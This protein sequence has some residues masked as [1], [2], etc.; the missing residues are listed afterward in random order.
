MSDFAI[1]LAKAFAIGV[2][3]VQTGKHTTM[4]SLTDSTDPSAVLIGL[5]L[6]AVLCTV[7]F[8]QSPSSE[9]AR[10]WK[11]LYIRGKAMGLPMTLISASLWSYLAYHSK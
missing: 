5:V 7:S 10:I 6:N 2:T 3:S 11:R 8:S 1:K 9:T 4:S